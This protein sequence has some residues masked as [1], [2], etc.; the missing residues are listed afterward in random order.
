VKK[1][2]ATIDSR[3]TLRSGSHLAVG[4]ARRQLCS[5]W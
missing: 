4:R 2:S 1:E 5:A 3:L